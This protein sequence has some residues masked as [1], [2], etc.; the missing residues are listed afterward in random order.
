[1]EI[2]IYLF[3]V[4]IISGY[5]FMAINIAKNRKKIHWV[6]FIAMLFF[7]YLWPFI[8]FYLKMYEYRK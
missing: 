1:M 2:L 6:N 5:I 8:Y 4:L 7:P 3:F